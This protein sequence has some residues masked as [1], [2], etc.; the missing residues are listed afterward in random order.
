MIADTARRGEPPSAACIC[1]GHGVHYRP[2]AALVIAFTCIIPHITASLFTRCSP[3]Y[4][5]LNYQFRAPSTL[6]RKVQFIAPFCQNSCFSSFRIGSWLCFR[7][8]NFWLSQDWNVST[9]ISDTLSVFASG[10][11]SL[12]LFHRFARA[13]DN[14]QRLTVPYFL[15]CKVQILPTRIVVF[16][17]NPLGNPLLQL[18]D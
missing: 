14:W 15:L 13:N 18:C 3:H 12:F 1:S 8:I 11:R 6:H 5:F 7:N 9:D 17:S 2:A 16:I 4:W 10:I